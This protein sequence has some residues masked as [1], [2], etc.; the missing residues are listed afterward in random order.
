M[1]AVMDADD[2]ANLQTC[3]AYVDS[4][5]EIYADKNIYHSYLMHLILKPDVLQ[6]LAY[7]LQ[8]I[9][10]PFLFSCP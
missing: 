7:P 9:S 6:K 5:N 1:S 4:L 3:R 2:K 10:N 8:A